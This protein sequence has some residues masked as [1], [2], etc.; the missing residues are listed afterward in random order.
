MLKKNKP[1]NAPRMPE[2]RTIRQ[3]SVNNAL[4]V[5]ENASAERLA[6][7]GALVFRNAYTA[8]A[9]CPNINPSTA[10]NGT[11]LCGFG[12]SLIPPTRAFTPL[13]LLLLETLVLNLARFSSLSFRSE[14]SNSSNASLARLISSTSRDVGFRCFISPSLIFSTNCSFRIKSSGSIVC[15]SRSFFQGSVKVPLRKRKHPSWAMTSSSLHKTK[16]DDFEEVFAP[17]PL[18]LGE[19]NNLALGDEEANNK[20][21][22]IIIRTRV[23][24]SL[25]IF[26]LGDFQFISKCFILC[27]SYSPNRYVV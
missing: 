19:T 22:I 14:A 24:K 27:G 1:K 4:A 9:S 23:I 6:A 7:N 20:I 13:I 3:F 8:N 26:L 15:I 17:S 25:C 11:D 12:A 5:P 16:P 21:I 10:L 2:K 18:L